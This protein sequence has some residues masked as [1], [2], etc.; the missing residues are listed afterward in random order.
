MTESWWFLV[1]LLGAAY[2]WG[3]FPTSYLLVRW[4][5]GVDLRRK[6]S[7][8]VGA[9][10][11]M[12]QMGTRVGILVGTFDCLAKGTL[13]IALVRGFDLSL[14][15]QVGTGLAA[16]AG[17]NW[18]PYLRFAGGR[19]LATAIG[20]LV[21]FLAWRE[22]LVLLVVGGVIGRLVTKQFALC[23]GIGVAALAPVAF[24]TG[25]P[26]TLVLFDLG[27]LG[28]AA[29]KRLTANWERPRPGQPLWKTL[30]YRLLY[31]RDVADH[32]SWIGRGVENPNLPRTR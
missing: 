22:A 28:L 23:M 13:P 8:N 6:G 2:L 11:V 12:V 31:D 19:G 20:G 10:N 27:V 26:R 29:L 25:G 7:G 4:A 21:G 15:V 32:K 5:K 24:L 16:I 3:A 14:P 30:C 1:L 9:A 17:H 18:S